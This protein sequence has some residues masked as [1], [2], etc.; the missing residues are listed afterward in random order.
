MRQNWK[1]YGYKIDEDPTQADSTE[2][3]YGSENSEEVD[4]VK[5]IASPIQKKRP[6]SSDSGSSNSSRVQS[7][8]EEI[9]VSLINK[10]DAKRV[11]RIVQ[12]QKPKVINIA[13]VQEKKP[14]M[15]ST[16]Q[17]IEM[18]QAI[19]GYRLALPEKRFAVKKNH[20]PEIMS[21]NVS[22]V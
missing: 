13:D 16:D 7:E 2:S 8:E 14:T 10:D 1:S 3:D 22:V 6:H 18:L 9:G 11:R 17:Q 15:M 19:E 20:L 21:S 12:Q 5:S 4:E